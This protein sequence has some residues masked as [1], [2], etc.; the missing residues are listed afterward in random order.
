MKQQ[1]QDAVPEIYRQLRQ[2]FR[3][4]PQRMHALEQRIRARAEFPA[5][6]SHAEPPEAV[7]PG[8]IKPHA[9]Q[10]FGAY[11]YAFRLIPLAA[12][13]ALVIAGAVYVGSD[14]RQHGASD[15]SS[16]SQ[17]DTN[18]ELIAVD[19][20][21]ETTQ[22]SLTTE[23]AT[24]TADTTSAQ[25]RPA[26]TTSA[27]VTSATTSAT[28]RTEPTQVFAVTTT[29]SAETI[30][31]PRTA[32][33]VPRTTTTVPRTT[34]TIPRTTTTVPRTTTTVPRTTT[35]AVRTTTVTTTV[36]AAPTTTV[37][38]ATTAA[39]IP[40]DV[41]V[42]LPHLTAKPGETVTVNAV[43]TQDITAAGVQLG[44]TLLAPENAPVPFVSA[45]DSEMCLYLPPNEPVLNNM[46]TS[47]YAAFGLNTNTRF[48]AG[49][50]AVQLTVTV[51]EDAASGTVY[52]FEAIADDK[53][54]CR[55]VTVDDSSDGSSTDMLV[56]SGS[57]TVQ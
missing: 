32:T 3:M 7:Q 8:H 41:H 2:E 15:D 39:P 21:T 54:L 30:T 50:A 19:S 53:F 6:G 24:D 26:Q 29:A 35:T 43:F 23:S 56:A 1:N 10:Q 48:P 36:T 37:T 45:I 17:Q 55:F 51:P 11:W 40:Q 38:T 44:L 4:P 49:T 22:T 9:K 47:F 28:A 31:F 46:F 14:L 18:Q 20:S 42:L 52:I 25:T 16:V 13:I 34:T 12:C 5:A 27:A 33:T 57:I